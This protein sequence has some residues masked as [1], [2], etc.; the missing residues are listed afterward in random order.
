MDTGQVYSQA[1]RCEKCDMRAVL[2]EE[3]AQAL[4]LESLGRLAM[5]RCPFRDA[6]HVWNPRA[7]QNSPHRPRFD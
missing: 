6:W 3:T 2:L 4:V 1:A 5:Y 7:E